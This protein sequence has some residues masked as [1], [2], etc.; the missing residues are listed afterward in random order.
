MEQYEFQSRVSVVQDVWQ[1]AGDAWVRSK[2]AKSFE[3]LDRTQERCDPC[4]QNRLTHR[5]SS[6]A[7]PVVNKGI[8]HCVKLKFS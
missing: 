5:D 2:I 6:S 8:G 1:R 7:K 3:V 4:P